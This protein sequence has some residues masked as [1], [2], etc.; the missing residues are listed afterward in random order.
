MCCWV[1]GVAC[2][3]G[4]LAASAGGS[5]SAP[6]C[7]F[8][9]SDAAGV[10]HSYDLEP[11]CRQAGQD[12]FLFQDKDGHEYYLQLCGRWSQRQCRPEG[13]APVAEGYAVQLW[14]PAPPCPSQQRNCSAPGHPSQCCTRPCEVLAADAAAWELMDPADAT[15][16]GLVGK[17][18][19]VP[20]AADDP[21]AR[22]CLQDTLEVRIVCNVRVLATTPT[23][24]YQNASDPTDPCRYVITFQSPDACALAVLSWGWV[25]IVVL[26]C[27]W[28]LYVMV[29]MAVVFVREGVWAYPNRN[30]WLH[31]RALVV[32]GAAFLASGCKPLRHA[33]RP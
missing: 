26:L 16:G 13:Y 32:D 31:A 20:R 23:E 21:T 25:A 30:G 17:F 6:S 4:R 3:V 22:T 15:S 33:H 24:L 18:P 8:D 12:G 29:G 27:A 10:T 9:L 7:K 5:C 2:V 14:G 11:A 1:L 28:S 19:P